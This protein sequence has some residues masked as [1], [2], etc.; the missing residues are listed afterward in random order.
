MSQGLENKYLMDDV[1]NRK[2]TPLRID[3]SSGG[4]TSI[5]ADVRKSQITD[6]QMK[7]FSSPRLNDQHLR[8]MTGVNTL[9]TP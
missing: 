2:G 4:L 6:D 1:E 5:E 7:S 3:P 9:S 8:P